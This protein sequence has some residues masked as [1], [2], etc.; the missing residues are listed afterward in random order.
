[1]ARWRAG[2]RAVGSPRAGAEGPAPPTPGRARA[3]ARAHARRGSDG[4]PRAAEALRRAGALARSPE[5]QQNLEA[6]EKTNALTLPPILRP[7]P[8]PKKIARP[9]QRAG[10]H[11]LERINK[12]T[13]PSLIANCLSLKKP[14]PSYDLISDDF[15]VDVKKDQEHRVS[16]VT[17]L[18]RH[19]KHESAENK[20]K[21]VEEARERSS[22]GVKGGRVSKR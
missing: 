16:D 18:I 6:R 21:R 9:K 2:A 1:V 22:P 7:L 14:T 8:P 5:T 15:K 12:H 10:Y 3:R 19:F 17:A 20:K 11:D 4:R 13:K